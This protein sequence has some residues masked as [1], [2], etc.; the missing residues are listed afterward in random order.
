LQ[1]K[2]VHGPGHV[3]IWQADAAGGL[4][5]RINSRDGL[6]AS[7][8]IEPLVNG[9]DHY[10]VG[11][12]TAGLYELV[13]QPSAR[14]LGSETFLLGE[15]VPVLFAVEPLPQLPPPPPLWQQWVQAQWPGGAPDAVL[16]PEA[17]PDQDGEPNVAE[18]LSGTDPR[19]PSNRPRLKLHPGSGIL[20]S[21]VFELPVETNR[22]GD[23]SVILESAPNLAGPWTAVSAIAPLGSS[24]RWEDSFTNPPSTRFYRR[25]TQKL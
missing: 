1:L 22:L 24:L 14:P 20:P 21:L 16:Q 10:S 18:F 23:A 11:F 15:S 19:N 7:D 9:H 12:T 3:F 6:D 25:R 8:R 2:S 5:V 17:D 13:F 4:D